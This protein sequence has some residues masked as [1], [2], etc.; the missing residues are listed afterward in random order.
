MPTKRVNKKARKTR[1]YKKSG[2]GKSSKLSMKS[3]KGTMADLF[4]K[5]AMKA[6][7]SRKQPIRESKARAE[8]LHQSVKQK[9]DK[10]KEIARLKREEKERHKR[11]M[12]DLAVLMED[13]QM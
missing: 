1:K 11:K 10:L 12:D 13:L 7:P 9:E 4:G 5:E 8:A 2:G 3:L 6:E